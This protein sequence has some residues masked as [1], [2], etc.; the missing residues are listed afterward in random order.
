MQLARTAGTFTKCDSV[1]R[2]ALEVHEMAKQVRKKTK[3]ELADSAFRQRA[4]SQSEVLLR[5]DA[6]CD[7][8]SKTR[9]QYI[10][11]VAE[12]AWVHR[13]ENGDDAAAFER[14]CQKWA[15]LRREFVKT[16]S[17]PLEI[18]C[19]TCRYN[20]SR[21]MQPLVQ[22]VKHPACDAGTALRLFWI[23]DPVYYS[24][25]ATIAD[26]PYE[27]EQAALK[28][29]QAIRRR[30]KKGDFQ[31]RKIYFDPKPWIEAGDV[32]LELL[33]IP[34]SMLAGVP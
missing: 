7:K 30:F 13:F 12:D 18:H 14:E 21:G 1:T 28:L 26:C 25:Y 31:T 17:K 34:E 32:D 8:L 16:V 23:N 11:D 33:K 6:E 29:L 3:A 24:Q 9:R 22:L 20:A 10:A 15:K 19:F 5:A 27:E 2:R 4:A